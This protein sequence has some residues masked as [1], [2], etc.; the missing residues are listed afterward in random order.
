MK[1]TCFLLLSLVANAKSSGYGLKPD[2]NWNYAATENGGENSIG[3][4]KWYQNY[5]ICDDQKQSPINILTSTVKESK[6]VGTIKMGEGWDTKFKLELTNIKKSV[7]FVPKV[8]KEEELPTLSYKGQTYRL[9]QFHAHWG[10]TNTDGSEH[11]IDFQKYA[12]EIHFVHYNTSYASLGDAMTEADGL[13]VWGH[14]L[15][16]NTENQAEDP[17]LNAVLNAMNSIVESDAK[18]QTANSYSLKSLLPTSHPG[19]YQIYTYEG[20]LTTPPCY[21]S[22]RWILNKTPILVSSTQMG[23]FRM[24]KDSAMG[25]SAMNQDNYRPLQLLHGRKITKNFGKDGK[26]CKSG[27]VS[28]QP[29]YAVVVTLLAAVFLQH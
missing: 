7:K 17:Q 24:L 6:D 11:A 12:G 20:S 19:F 14:F 25:D 2:G 3:P 9:A 1:L 4:N 28:L 27:S 23:W 21:E 22:V 15:K 10:S 13:L 16:V 5:E 26:G 18:V 8:A 29:L